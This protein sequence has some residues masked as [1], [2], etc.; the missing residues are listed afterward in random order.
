MY[1]Y[2]EKQLPYRLMILYIAKVQGKVQGFI[3]MQLIIDNHS[4]DSIQKHF[5]QN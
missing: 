3:H 2:S 1:D 4:T 5:T